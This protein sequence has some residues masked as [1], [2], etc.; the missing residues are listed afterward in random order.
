MC[1]LA[2]GIS[3]AQRREI[4]EMDWLIR[5]IRENGPA[6]TAQEAADRPVPD[7]P[8]PADRTCDGE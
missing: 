6:T 7:F 2:V 3:E 1:E 8:A 4:D 5:D